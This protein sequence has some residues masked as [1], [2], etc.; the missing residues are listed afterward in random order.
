MA[1]SLTAIE[2]EYA[3]AVISKCCEHGCRVDFAGL[4]KHVVLKGE[5]LAGK[6]DAVCDC[7]VFDTRKRL[8]ASLIELKSSSLNADKIRK[9][10]EGGGKKALEIAD[11]LGWPEPHL[12]VALVA[13]S[14]SRWAQH[15][16]L[17]KTKVSIG[18]KKHQIALCLCNTRLVDME[19]F[20]EPLSQHEHGRRNAGDVG[21]VD[22]RARTRQT[23]FRHKGRH[24]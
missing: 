19:N 6:Q 13:K 4:S 15:V 20:S 18:Q 11:K 5:I 17:L 10:F 21:A 9:Q 7:I 23:R 3:D 24:G 16:T 12:T 8:T 2:S 14:Y 22:R 1:R